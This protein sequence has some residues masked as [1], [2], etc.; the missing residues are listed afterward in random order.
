MYQIY[1]ITNSVNGKIYVGQTMRSL[2][3]RWKDH[4]RFAAKG[5]KI[6]FCSAIRKYEAN[7]FT[8]EQI[9]VAETREEANALE[10]HWIKELNTTDNSVGY[11]STVGGEGFS[12]GVLNPYFGQDRSGSNNPNFGKPMSEEQKAKIS[13]TLTGLLVGEKN[14]FFGKK[15]T[16]ETRRLISE[17]QRGQKR[18]PCSEEKKRKISEAQKGRTK[19]EEMKQRIRETCKGRIVTPEAEANRLASYLRTVAKRKAQ[20]VAE[21]V[22]Q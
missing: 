2:G 1:K 7:S 14:P 20:Q 21:L 8:I 22:L 10:R 16:E 18:K 19:S 3:Q 11:N 4:V 5:R 17:Q 12:S 9:A 13:L 15:H 6:Y